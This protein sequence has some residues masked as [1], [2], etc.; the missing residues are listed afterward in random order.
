MLLGADPLLLE[1]VAPDL[2]GPRAGPSSPAQR[3]GRVPTTR[4]EVDWEQLRRVETWVM[5]E[6][7]SGPRRPVN[8]RPGS[9]PRWLIRPEISRRCRW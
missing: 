5:P 6:T 1:F 7:D 2:A 3:A 9:L 8:S 4:T